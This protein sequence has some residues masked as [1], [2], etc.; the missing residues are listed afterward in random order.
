MV[1]LSRVPS[2]V[3][4]GNL[5]AFDVIRTKALETVGDD[6]V[7]MGDKENCPCQHS[8]SEAKRLSPAPLR[9]TRT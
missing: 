2:S 9:C 5:S 7:T 3:S 8:N 6:V 1:L 4:S